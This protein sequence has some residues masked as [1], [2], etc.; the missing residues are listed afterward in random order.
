MDRETK[1]TLEQVV[2][3]A[4]QLSPVD[5]VRLI[6]RTALEIERDMLARRPSSLKS[7]LGLCADLGPAPSAE[8]IEEIRREMW[9]S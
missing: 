5:K 1:V 9:S 2:A 6:A 7:L 4:Q 3:L 8:D